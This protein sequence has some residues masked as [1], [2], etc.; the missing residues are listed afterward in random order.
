MDSI[1][2]AIIDQTV[3]ISQKF[4]NSKKYSKKTKKKMSETL[5]LDSIHAMDRREMQK[6][7]KALKIKAN[8]KN[9]VMRQ[10]LIDWIST[11]VRRLR[12]RSI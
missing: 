7:C 3:E 1:H 4:K 12:R 2:H 6:H 5:T 10:H 11:R 8:K 9:D